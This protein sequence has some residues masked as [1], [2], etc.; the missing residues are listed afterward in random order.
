MKRKS[1]ETSVE[2][3][4]KYHQAENKS[5]NKP[6]TPARSVEMVAGRDAKDY[7]PEDGGDFGID[8]DGGKGNRWWK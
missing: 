4:A 6:K 8:A 2:F 7:R 1:G 3:N 5:N